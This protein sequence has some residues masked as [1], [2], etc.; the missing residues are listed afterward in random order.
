MNLFTNTARPVLFLL[1]VLCT[2]DAI[3]TYEQIN[4]RL[5]FPLELNM[6]PYTKEG[7]AAA[8]VGESSVGGCSVKTKQEVRKGDTRQGA[9][10]ESCTAFRY[11]KHLMHFRVTAYLDLSVELTTVCSRCP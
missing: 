7:R 8:S 5:E 3:D 10:N 4:D 1:S 9:G 11:I 2:Y 6:Y